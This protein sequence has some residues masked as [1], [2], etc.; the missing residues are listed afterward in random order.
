MLL[1]H[2]VFFVDG[3]LRADVSVRCEGGAIRQVGALSPLPGEDVLDA[4]GAYV[5]P[6][7]VDIHIHGFAGRDCME[8]EDA[9]RAMSRG[10]AGRGVAAFVPTTMSAPPWRASGPSWTGPSRQAR[11]CWARTWR[12]RFSAP[13]TA[14]RSAPS[15][16]SAPR[17]RPT[18]R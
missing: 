15:A 3:A 13:P 16:C 9:V 12:R 11:R 8:G 7:F 5:L 10:L 17:P 4:G 1:T 14:A 2:G 6:G 18:M